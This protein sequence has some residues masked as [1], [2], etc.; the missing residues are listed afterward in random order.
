[1]IRGGRSPVDRVLARSAAKTRAVREI[2]A[3]EHA[4]LGDGLRAVVLCDHERATAVLPARLHGV[5]DEQAGSAQ[6]VLRELVADDRTTGL[7]PM[8]VTGRTVAAGA[9]TA[10]RFMEFCAAREPGLRLAL[11]SVD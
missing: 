8:L 1:G 6:L 4:A 10:G 11:S 3:A 5:L 9:E 7:G 2:L